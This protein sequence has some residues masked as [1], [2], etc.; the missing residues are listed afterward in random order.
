MREN[1]R[2]DEVEQMS[3]AETVRSLSLAW[4]HDPIRAESLAKGASREIALTGDTTTVDDTFVL[5]LAR[6]EFPVSE[7]SAFATDCH[8]VWRRILSGHL[9]W[10][11]VVRTFPVDLAIDGIRTTKPVHLT[12][13]MDARCLVV[14]ACIPTG[15]PVGEELAIHRLDGTVT[16]TVDPEPENV[17]VEKRLLDAAATDAALARIARGQFPILQIRDI[18]KDCDI[19]LPQEDDDDR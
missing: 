12:A 6:L 1:D 9:P 18:A 15:Q 8:T 11:C 13:Y 3:D 7:M 4:G 10:A 5:M 19:A 2:T 14:A 17:P 16:G